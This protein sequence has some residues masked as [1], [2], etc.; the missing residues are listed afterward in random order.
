MSPYRSA[1]PPKRTFWRRLLCA[2]GFHAW[3][4]YDWYDRV[5]AEG[6]NMDHALKSGWPLDELVSYR[7]SCACGAQKH[8]VRPPWK[9][10]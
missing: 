4:G 1:A 8:N 10:Q 5:F 9:P 7:A 3:E 6:V 2:L